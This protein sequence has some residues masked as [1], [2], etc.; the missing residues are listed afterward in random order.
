[1]MLVFLIVKP[2]SLHMGEAVDKSLK[3]L[4]RVSGQSFKEYLAYKNLVHSDFS[5]KVGQ[6]EETVIPFG[7]EV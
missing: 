3:C 2:N 4:L 5:T 1:M 7:V 6:V